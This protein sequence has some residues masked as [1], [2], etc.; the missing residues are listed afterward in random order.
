MFAL[1]QQFGLSEERPKYLPKV[2]L[3]DGSKDGVLKNLPLIF[4]EAGFD[5]SWA[6]TTQDAIN[7]LVKYRH[8]LGYVIVQLDIPIVKNCFADIDNGA[9]VLKALQAILA[10]NEREG[11]D[12]D[13]M[14]IAVYERID[15]LPNVPIDSMVNMLWRLPI[16]GSLDEFL[17]RFN[18]TGLETSQGG[19]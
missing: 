19:N 1:K 9:F 14:V 12:V 5:V 7:S 6:H 17:K 3:V 18:L 13:P 16:Q 4:T 11:F 15:Y 8:S 10:M 2:L